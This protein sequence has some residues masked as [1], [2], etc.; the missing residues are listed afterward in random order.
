MTCGISWKSYVINII[1][2][3]Q[4]EYKTKEEASNSRLN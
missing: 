3:G 1:K 4:S 2:Y